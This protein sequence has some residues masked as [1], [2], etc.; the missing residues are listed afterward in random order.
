MPLRRMSQL[1]HPG[2]GPPRESTNNPPLQLSTQNLPTIAED[3]EH[4]TFRDIPEV[5]LHQPAHISTTVAGPNQ[6]SSAASSTQTGGGA[7]HQ[8][9]LRAP[10]PVHMIQGDV[11]LYQVQIHD[12]DEEVEEDKA[13]VEEELARVQ[14][15]IERL[16]IEQESILRRQTAVRRAEARRQSINRERARFAELQY[17]LDVLCHQEQKQEAPLDQIP[18]Q[19]PPLPPHN[20]N[21]HQP[22]PP[23]LHNHFFHQQSPRHKSAPQTPKARWLSTYNSH[24][25]LCTI[26]Q[27][28]FQSTTA[29]P[30]PTNFSCVTKL[31]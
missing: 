4:P 17:T 18:H 6:N 25:G 29:T 28:H 22:P 12:W 3:P 23:P 13:A 2:E 1:L 7:P 26:E 8:S 5:Q 10:S 14:Q 9:P 19:P 11:E 20:K 15:E 16:R 24:H 30:T 27:C 31:P 21:L